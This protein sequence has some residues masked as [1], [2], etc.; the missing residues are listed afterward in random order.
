MDSTCSGQDI[1]RCNLCETP[2]PQLHCDIF[3]VNLCQGC[4]GEN[5]LVELQNIEPKKYQEQE[6]ETVPNHQGL[7]KCHPHT[8]YSL[9]L[10]ITPFISLFCLMKI[11]SI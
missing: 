4:A 10:I 2:V 5:V 9:L 11:D 3:Y 7:V 6:K 8:V 1:L